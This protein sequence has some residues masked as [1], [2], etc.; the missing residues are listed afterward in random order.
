MREHLE[1]L[2]DDKDPH[3]KIDVVAALQS[4]GDLKSRGALHRAK[5]RELDGRVVR[6][7]REA[8]RDMGEHKTVAERKRLNDAA[9][10][11]AL[12][13]A[14]AQSAPVQARGRK[15]Q[16]RRD[17]QGQSQTKAQSRIRQEAAGEGP[18]VSEPVRL[19]RRAAAAIVTIDR[20][21]R[22]NALSWATVRQLGEIGQELGA[23]PS[24]RVCVLT[25]AGD[26]PSA[27]G[28]I[29]KSAKA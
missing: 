16:A 8:L 26:K 24:V 18:R 4:L 29:S 22:M 6:R 14:R 2:L 12:R 15:V 17:R 25:G 21:D 13:S 9:R 11:R 28:P 20:P 27:P 23:D 1:D 10:Q 5:E 7:L 19:E 3:L